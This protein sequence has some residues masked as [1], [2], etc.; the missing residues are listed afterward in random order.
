MLVV[1][2]VVLLVLEYHPAAVCCHRR[3][4][5]GITLAQAAADEVRFT[6]Q[7]RLLPGQDSIQQ[8]RQ[9]KQRVPTLHASCMHAC[10]PCCTIKDF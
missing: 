8:G 1:G 5:Y 4:R 6:E 3:C 2:P 10:M 9:G 7:S